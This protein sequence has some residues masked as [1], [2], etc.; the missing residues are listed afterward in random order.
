MIALGRADGVENVFDDTYSPQTHH[1][2]VIFHK[3]QAWMYAVLRKVVRTP[4]GMRYVSEA[5][6]TFDAQLVLYCPT[7]SP[8]D[9][10]TP[11]LTAS[12]L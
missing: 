5:R 10:R 2:A 8:R 4:E 11:L 1:D 6:Q 12:A 7:S 9:Q 3:M